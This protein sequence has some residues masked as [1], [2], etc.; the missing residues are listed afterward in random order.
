MLDRVFDGYTTTVSESDLLGARFNSFMENNLLVFCN[1]LGGMGWS[2]R[3][4]GYETLK[5]RVDPAHTQITIERKGL[6]AYRTETFVSFLMAT[7]QP[8]ALT[9]DAEDRRF[10]FI[11]NGKKLGGALLSELLGGG[12]DRAVEGLRTI[13]TN[14]EITH[15]V[16]D[17]PMFAGREAMLT[18][19]D[20][21]LDEAIMKVISEASEH[22]AW[23]RADFEKAL[24]LEVGGSTTAKV[25]G[26]R[27]AVTN[28]VGLRAKRMGAMLLPHKVK[29]GNSSVSLLAKDPDLIMKL[30]P[31]GRAK[32]CS[33]VEIDTDETNVVPMR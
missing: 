22:R 30:D 17:A 12:F 25:P 3:K 33:G 2:E 8:G 31:E 6:E 20:T 26:L 15:T 11:T 28:M 21:E 9:I 24:K 23:K 10:A 19:N 29:V 7:N 27:Q 18:A 4:R 5:D 13:I 14:R 1:E 32:I 16:S